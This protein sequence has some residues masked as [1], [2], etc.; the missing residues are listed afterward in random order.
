MDKS[1]DI[2]ELYSL[3]DIV[4]KKYPPRPLKELTRKGLPRQG[5]YFFFEEGEY[6]K[7]SNCFRVVRVGTHAVQAKAKTILHQR[8]YNH[9][10]TRNLAGDH[11]TSVF[12]KL[13]GQC[14]IKRDDRLPD[15]WDVKGK[16][17]DKS[18][19]LRERELEQLV[20][21]YLQDMEFTVLEVPGDSSKTND[22]AFIERNTISLLSNFYGHSPH[23]S[24]SKW[25]GHLTNE[26]LVQQSGLW[27]RDHV[28]IRDNDSD[29]LARFR[30]YVHQMSTY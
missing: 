9:K 7:D 17:I 24:S 8:L 21:A 29:Y 25:L 12:R 13:I 11:R 20:S 3:L 16:M 18:V 28:D 27:N 15:L 23:K 1:K 2:S 6:L 14:F 26:P 4:R 22:R 19:R 10:G 5:V 30:K